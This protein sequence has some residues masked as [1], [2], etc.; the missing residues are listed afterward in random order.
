MLA[1][2]ARVTAIDA[3]GRNF[4]DDLG[5]GD[6]WNFQAG[7]P[8]SIQ[9]LAD[10]CEF[11]LVFDDGM[12]SENE[13]FLLTDWFDHTPL[14]VLAKNLGVSP[15][16]LA[17]IPRDPNHERYIFSG[18]VPPPRAQDVVRSPAGEVPVRR[19]LTQPMAVTDPAAAGPGPPGPVNDVRDHLEQDQA[20]HH[21]VGARARAGAP[22]QPGAVRQWLEP[23]AVPPRPP[24][25]RPVRPL[26]DDDRLGLA[27]GDRGR[28]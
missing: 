4:I 12:F 22:G 9:A 18:E 23:A 8:H 3:D 15:D 11:L 27:R 28:R 1:G 19:H 10:G 5:P 20:D 6:L 14:A 2:H 16:A 17:R 21:P 13:T 25:A 24:P 7:L 26:P